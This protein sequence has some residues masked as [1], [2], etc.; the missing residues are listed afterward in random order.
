MTCL[1]MTIT[2]ALH[3]WVLSPPSPTQRHMIV[4]T[5]TGKVI[6]GKVNLGK[7]VIGEVGKG[8]GEGI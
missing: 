8:K 1:K 6:I 7:F 2:S 3:L 4:Q 5:Q